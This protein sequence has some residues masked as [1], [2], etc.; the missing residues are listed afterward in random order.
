[1]PKMMLMLSLTVVGCGSSDKA[2]APL[3]IDINS[4][5]PGGDMDPGL[6][7][8]AAAHLGLEPEALISTEDAIQLKHLDCIDEGLTSIEGI[9]DFTALQTLS[10]WENSIEDLSPLQSLTTL[11]W[12]ELGNNNIT[13][14]S[15]L[16]ELT[17]LERLGLSSNF[18]ED[19]DAVAGLKDLKWLNLDGNAIRSAE[20]LSGLSEITWLTIEHNQIEDDEP[21]EALSDGGADVYH[22]NQAS[23]DG[24]PAAPEI[25]GSLDIAIGTLSPR[26]T[27]TGA[28]TFDLFV[29]SKSYPVRSEFSGTLRAEGD[30]LILSRSG[31][32]TVVG[33][34]DGA[35][36]SLCDDDEPC[37]TSL[38]VKIGPASAYDGL[39]PEPV[40]SLAIGLHAKPDVDQGTYG[41]SDE[42]LIDYALASPN[43][44]DAGSCLFMTTTGA[45]ELL[46]HQ[47]TGLEDV[48]Y[49]GDTDLSER[50][51][52]AAYQD[53]SSAQ[54]R[55]W[56]TDTVYTYNHHGGSMLNRDYPFTAGYVRDTGSGLVPC[57]S[58]DSGAY[59]SCSYNWF[60]QRPD[61]WQALMVETP[62]VERTVA[63]TDPARSSSSQ[64]NVGLMDDEDV[65]KIKYMLRTRRAPVVVIYNHYLYWHADMIV[66]YD[67]TV[68]T[69]GCPM[70]DSSMEYFDDEGASGYTQKIESH[71]DDIGDCTSQGIF[72]VRD[73]IYDGGSDELTYEY[74]SGFSEKY[75]KRII[76]RT[77]NWVKYLG[78]HAYSIHRK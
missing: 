41:Q 5:R 30:Q 2:D 78:N 61:G 37:V 69:D 50:F 46:L 70:V 7:A 14:M 76:E 72:Y 36:A 22:Q 28:V 58:D 15:P 39:A 75:S 63:Y 51:L 26:L 42:T 9:D 71:M 66:G 12:L 62:A 68:E 18:I 4:L 35:T 52:M 31:H 13:D 44:F 23:G 10:L 17:A 16:S 53:V 56:L 54:M 64:W 43:Q 11:K 20:A 1:M 29:G 34:T 45:M 47:H 21:V 60:D 48:S 65:E 55:Y 74:S 6:R 57:D 49:N 38:G 27:A 25:S 19:I 73:S 32:D 33:S 40:V 3:L 59:Y 67:D 77:Y 8:C 24:S